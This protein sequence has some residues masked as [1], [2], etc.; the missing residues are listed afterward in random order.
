MKSSAI[1]TIPLDTFITKDTEQQLNF[2]VLNGIVTVENLEMDGL[3]NGINVTKLDQESVKLNGEQYVSSNLH[4]NNNLQVK[5]LKIM[6]TLNDIEMANYV[7]KTQ[8]LENTNE[9]ESIHVENLEIIGNLEATKINFDPRTYD[10][11]RLS[12]TKEQIIESPF[13]VNNGKIHHL[14]TKFVNNIP[15]TNIFGGK[16][17][18][19]AIVAKINNREL[20][21]HGKPQY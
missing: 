9:I 13:T 16:S 1:N 19:D 8:I 12:K 17:V 11:R 4:F 18:V 3:F 20:P 14:R 15:Y 10:E 2:G 6:E 5:E 7:L 21:I